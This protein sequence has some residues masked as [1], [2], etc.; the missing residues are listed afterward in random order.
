M[1][2]TEG[3]QQGEALRTYPIMLDLRG[4]RAVVVGGGPVGLRKVRSLVD[5]GANVTLVAKA[6]ADDEDLRGVAV[7]RQGY[8][9]EMLAGAFLVFACTD[10]RDANARIAADA[11]KAGALCN[12]ADQ[13]DDCDFF[14]PACIRDGDVVLAI[15]TGGRCPALAAMLKRKLQTAVPP[16]LGCFAELLGDLRGKLQAAVPSP[17][18]RG[19]IMKELVCEKTFEA[20]RTQGPEAVRKLLAKLTEG[21]S[22]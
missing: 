19:R 11:R 16:D 8:R 4:R 1:M 7:I 9:P 17:Q 10:E 3:R 15:G 12:A 14:L 22:R 21:H 2:W 18:R 20:F 13:P 5:A 6:L